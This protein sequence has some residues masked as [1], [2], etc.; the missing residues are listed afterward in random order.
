LTEL[1]PLSPRGRNRASEICI[2]IVCA[3]IVLAGTDFGGARFRFAVD[4]YG[5]FPVKGLSNPTD[6]EEAERT[7]D[8]P[9]HDHLFFYSPDRKAHADGYAGFHDF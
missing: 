4:L 9:S 3:D 5:A 7:A 8:H 2:G 6:G 1:A